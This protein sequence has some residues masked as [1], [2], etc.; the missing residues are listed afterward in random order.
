MYVSPFWFSAVRE[1]YGEDLPQNDIDKDFLLK[2]PSDQVGPA[3]LMVMVTSDVKTAKQI[4]WL[5]TLLF[6][7]LKIH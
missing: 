7:I 6:F 3:A 1:A 5:Y 4:L 2:A